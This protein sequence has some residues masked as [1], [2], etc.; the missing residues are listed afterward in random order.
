M[1]ARRILIDGRS[2]SGKTELA[3]RVSADWP[4]A[5]LVRMDDLYPGWDGLAAG[6]AVVPELLAGGEYQTW[7]WIRDRPGELR[8]ID[9]ARPLIVEGVGSLTR[10]SRPLADLAIWVEYP[11]ALR[12]ER[13]LDRDGELFAPHWDDWAA[14]EDALLAV[15]RPWELAD[16][17][18]PGD[19]LEL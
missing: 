7:D 8:R 9:P 14:Q 1:I 5:Q 19:A 11:A 12:K 18:V 2:G 13:A 17:V 16:L 10:A 6:S 15:E 3:A 4:A